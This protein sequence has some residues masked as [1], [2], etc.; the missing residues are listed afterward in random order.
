M[1]LIRN[2]QFQSMERQ[3]VR[4]FAGRAADFL[5]KHFHGAQTV[6][7]EK[8]VEEILPLIDKAQHYGFAGE[9][10]V[11]AY[12]VTAAYLGR[13]FDEALEQAN[14]ILRQS[15]DS[16]A[17]KARKLETLTAEIVARLQA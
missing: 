6:S 2:D 16:S 3:S 1:L 7:R 4:S 12:I 11:V 13:N 8:L 9:R 17:V 10:D 5:K 15:T 14:V